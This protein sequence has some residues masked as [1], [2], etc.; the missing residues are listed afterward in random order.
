MHNWP[1]GTRESRKKPDRLFE[2]V[3]TLHSSEDVAKWKAIC[4]DA[5]PTVLWLDDLSF[6][7]NSYKIT[8]QA[9]EERDQWRQTFPTS[10]RHDETEQSSLPVA[11]GDA[12]PTERLAHRFVPTAGTHEAYATFYP[13]GEGGL[14]VLGCR[15]ISSASEPAQGEP[16][17]PDIHTMTPQ[18]LRTFAATLGLPV[19]VTEPKALL[20][21][22]V[23]ARLAEAVVA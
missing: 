9:T 6:S 5:R 13:R 16:S 8:C 19:K 7:I 11:N 4:Q 12:K 21:E 20:L 2:Q 15:P 23:K 22:R 10:I 3:I 18:Q 14:L 17:R 1:A